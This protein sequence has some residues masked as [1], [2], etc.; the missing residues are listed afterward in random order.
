MMLMTCTT[1][2]KLI[3]LQ[4]EKIC[5]FSG[6]KMRMTGLRACLPGAAAEIRE[7]GE[8]HTRSSNSSKGRGG[9]GSC[10]HR[11]LLPQVSI[12]RL[13]STPL[14]HTISNILFED[15][16]QIPRAAAAAA[17]EQQGSATR[18]ANHDNQFKKKTV[19][20]FRKPSSTPLGPLRLSTVSPALLFSLHFS[21]LI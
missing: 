3:Q 7:N 15:S 16:G 9:G 21:M 1:A 11:A 10:E 17:A 19:L 5:P 18:S 13:Q 20:M 8:C 2:V 4:P 6:Y 14:L 12:E